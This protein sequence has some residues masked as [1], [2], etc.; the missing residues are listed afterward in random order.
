MWR[1]LEIIDVALQLREALR[2]EE[3]LLLSIQ[4]SVTAVTHSNSKKKEEKKE[5][6]KYYLLHLEH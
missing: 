3:T 2:T 6:R 1:N 5:K 4:S